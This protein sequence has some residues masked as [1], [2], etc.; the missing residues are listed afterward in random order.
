MGASRKGWRWHWWMRTEP[1]Q[2]LRSISI[3]VD[4]AVSENYFS[5]HGI[6]RA[7]GSISGNT[8]DTT[9]SRLQ[10]VPPQLTFYA[11]LGPTLYPPSAFLACVKALESSNNHR[12]LVESLLCARHCTSSLILTTISVYI[13]NNSLMLWEVERPVQGH[14]AC[15]WRLWN[16]ILFSPKFMLPWLSHS[17]PCSYVPSLRSP[18]SSHYVLGSSYFLHLLWGR[19]L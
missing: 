4:R 10:P 18:L 12:P 13:W 19:H 5:S 3:F 11:F 16:S 9:A 15:K 2:I 17:V 1:M 6:R 8:S 7:S 14:S